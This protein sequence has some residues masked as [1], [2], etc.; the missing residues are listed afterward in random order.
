MM[1]L[2][3]SGNP[4]ISEAGKHDKYVVFRTSHNNKTGFGFLHKIVADCWVENDN[5]GVKTQVNHKDGDKE[6]CTP[7][8]LEWVTA[9]QNQRHALSAGLK[10]QGED[11]YNASLSETEV[12][13]I[14]QMLLD[15]MR[16]VDIHQ[17]FPNT[18]KDVIRKIASGDCYMHIRQLYPI[19]YNYK[20]TLSES[21]VRWIC[22]NILQGYSSV[23]IAKMSTNNHV[24]KY[25]VNRIRYKIRYKIISDEFF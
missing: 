17:Y 22:H 24:T 18:S 21:T 3:L 11:L 12:H 9:S 16:G 4:R 15:G 25:E 14:C 6:N 19:E 10:Q 2:W 20:N 8:N 23:N 5:P 1:R 13:E 7:S